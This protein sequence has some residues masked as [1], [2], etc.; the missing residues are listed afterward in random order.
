MYQQ[1]PPGYP[2]A[3]PPGYPGGPPPGYPGAPPVGYPVGVPPPPM[4]TTTVVHH[5]TNAADD[6]HGC[7]ADAMVDVG[8]T[9]AAIILLLNIFCPQLGTLIAACMDRRGFNCSTLCLSFL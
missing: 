1:P 3:P 6:Y 8:E 5:K 4:V 2:G 7:C 9:E